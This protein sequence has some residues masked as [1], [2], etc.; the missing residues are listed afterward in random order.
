MHLGLLF[1]LS[2]LP[3]FQRHCGQR[4]LLRLNDMVFADVWDKAIVEVWDKVVV[5]VVGHGGKREHVSRLK[6]LV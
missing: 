5:E 1:F 2:A 6:S 4:R 3:F